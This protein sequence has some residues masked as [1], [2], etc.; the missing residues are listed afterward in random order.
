MW[1]EE[2]SWLRLRLTGDSTYGKDLAEDS[3]GMEPEG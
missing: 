2:D 1:E 3:T